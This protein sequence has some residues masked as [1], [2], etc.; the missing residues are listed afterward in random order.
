MNLI[1]YVGKRMARQVE[2]PTAVYDSKLS[3]KTISAIKAR[4]IE[5]YSDAG[6]TDPKQIY[7]NHQVSKD[8][9]KVYYYLLLPV[10]DDV[11]N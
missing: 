2:L 5:T 9:K 11:K 6:I 8:E 10:R 1:N 4:L 7:F 3:Q